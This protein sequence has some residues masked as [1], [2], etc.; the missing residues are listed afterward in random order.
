MTITTTERPSVSVHPSRR[1]LGAAAAGVAAEHLRRALRSRGAATVMLAAAPSQEATLLALAE[2]PRLSWDRVT[3]YHMDDY[4]GLDPGAPQGFGAWLDRT[5]ISRLPGVAF[6]RIPVDGDPETCADLYAAQLPPAAFDLV[7]LGLGVNGHLA[8]NDPPARFDDPHDTRV[9]TLDKVSRRQQ[10]DEGH[11][12]DL[13]A[14]PARA[15]TVTIPRL[16]HADHIVTSVPGTE[17]RQ[18]VLDTLTAPIGPDHPST[19]LRTHPDV[20]LFL[21]TESAP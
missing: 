14:V 2:E 13:D 10:V 20:V 11:F 7:L 15:I 3:C 5:F 17:K 6:H 4:V 8:F 21:D 1:E 18:A 9:V 12:P 19:A 16:L